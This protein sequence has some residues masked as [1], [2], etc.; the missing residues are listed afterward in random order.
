MWEVIGIGILRELWGR[1]RGEEA[2]RM[3]R[4]HFPNAPDRVGP[5]SQ[6][7]GRI[8]EF[9]ERHSLPKKTSESHSHARFCRGSSASECNKAF[10]PSFILTRRST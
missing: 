10:L 7:R 4:E 9:G 2:G 3:R 5:L 6:S 1:A 8:Y